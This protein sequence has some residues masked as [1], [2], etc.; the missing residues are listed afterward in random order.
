MTTLK[1]VEESRKRI[2][3]NRGEERRELR[4]RN[5][6]ICAVRREHQTEKG[7]LA[8]TAGITVDHLNRILREGGVE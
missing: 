2:E 5:M 3:E 1:D 8:R 7:V 4:E 6:R